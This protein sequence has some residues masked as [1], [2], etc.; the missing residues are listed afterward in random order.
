MVSERYPRD[1]DEDSASAFDSECCEE[2]ESADVV[3]LSNSTQDLEFSP[4]EDSI[5][6]G[7]F[8][9]SDPSTVQSASITSIT[10]TIDG[11]TIQIGEI[12]SLLV[13]SN[14]NVESAFAASK[15]NENS[16]NLD[17]E[18]VVSEA[19]KGLNERKSE[20]GVSAEIKQLQNQFG[21]QAYSSPIKVE[22]QHDGNTVRFSQDHDQNSKKGDMLS[23]LLLCSSE[24]IVFS[25]H[26]R[27]L[28]FTVFDP[29]L[30]IS[31]HRTS[32][33]IPE[34][35]FSIIV[36]LSESIVDLSGITA[37]GIVDYKR[38][39]AIEEFSRERSS[40]SGLQ[41]HVWRSKSRLCFVSKGKQIRL[42]GVV[43]WLNRSRLKV[44][45]VVSVFHPHVQ[46]LGPD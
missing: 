27:D 24:S 43:V 11:F 30:I 40:E 33:L 32:F 7:S 45:E 29:D 36:Y 1:E 35:M 16:T 26:H 39:D 34:E 3:I 38:C 20:F 46:C 17:S 15:E 10:P 28:G 12:A 42:Q 23:D 14:C 31:N 6:F 9:N 22:R 13:S 18:I 44:L 25:S 8:G 41:K 4:S 19:I 21:V 2:D 37:I 5:S